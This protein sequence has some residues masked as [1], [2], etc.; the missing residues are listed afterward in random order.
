MHLS[1]S[2]CLSSFTVRQRESV[3]AVRQRVC[4]W[5]HGNLVFSIKPTLLLGITPSVR[6]L[7]TQ[8]FEPLHLTPD[9]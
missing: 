9:I 8:V 7:F 1:L 4:V 2:R 3:C 5:W 6:G